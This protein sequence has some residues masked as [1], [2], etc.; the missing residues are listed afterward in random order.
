MLRWTYSGVCAVGKAFTNSQSLIENFGD[1]AHGEALSRAHDP[2][3]IDDPFA[4]RHWLLVAFIIA[5][6]TGQDERDLGGDPRALNFSAPS[7]RF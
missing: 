2:L 1:E 4:R 7:R 6:R 5:W 3:A